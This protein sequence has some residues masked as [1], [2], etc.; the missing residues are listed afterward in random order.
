MLMVDFD[1]TPPREAQRRSNASW[2]GRGL[3]AVLPGRET[4]FG[5]VVT[6][7]TVMERHVGEPKRMSYREMAELMQH[8]RNRYRSGG[9]GCPLEPAIPLAGRK[10]VGI[11]K[12]RRCW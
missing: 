3:Q 6:H 4:R 12:N 10:R 7:R 11:P 5:R 8:D 1:S 2:A 9:S